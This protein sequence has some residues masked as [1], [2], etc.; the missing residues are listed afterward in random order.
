MPLTALSLAL[1]NALVRRVAVG[2]VLPPTR[3][4]I[5]IQVLFLEYSA[6]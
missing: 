6:L 2:E 5:E 4:S 1:R 3:E